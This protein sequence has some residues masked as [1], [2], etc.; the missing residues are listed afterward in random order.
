MKFWF[1][2]LLLACSACI[3]AEVPLIDFARHE[4][5]HDVKISPNGEYLAA[6]AVVNG[7]MVLTLLHLGDLKGVNIVPRE[8]DEL[9]QFWW[10]APTRVMYTVGRKI[11]G[12]EVPLA[13][14]ELFTVAADGSEQKMIFGYGGGTNFQGAT[15][16]QHA[17]SEAAFGEF[18]APLHDDPNS[19]L[20]ASYAVNGA[21]LGNVRTASSIGVFPEAFRIDLRTGSKARV[22]TSPLRNAQFI[23]D[24]KGVVRIAYGIDVDR[25]EKVYYRAGNGAD[26]E[27]IFDQSH[28]GLLVEP[29]AFGSDA[30]TLYLTCGGV[31]G[32]G[33]IC[34]WDSQTRKIQTVWSGIE[35]GPTELMLKADESDAFAIESMPGRPAVSL[36]DKAAPDAK[37]IADLMQQFSGQRV[38]LGAQTIDGTKRIVSVSG[39]VNPGEFYLLDLKT[40]K[41][42]FLLARRPWLKSEQL[43]PMEP[44]KIAARDGVNLHGYLTRPSGKPDAKDAPLVVYVHGGP[45]GVRDFWQ[46][47]PEVQ[48]LASRGYAVLQ[49]NYRGS[50]GY[51]EKFQQSGFREWGGKMQDDI[52]DATHW[53]IEQGI[54]NPKRICI[55]G[56]SYG[57]YAALEGAVREPDLYKCTIGNAGIYDLRLMYSRGDIP[58]SIFGEN[59]LKVVLGE[60]QSQLYDRSPIAHLDKL[61]AHVMLI[62]GGADVR[63]P[64]V[65]AENLHNALNQRKIDHEWIYERTEGHGFYDEKHIVGMYEKILAFLD[66]EI[67]PASAVRK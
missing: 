31:N 61:K 67:G 34:R 58:Q 44:F 40:K 29:R 59:Y 4:R 62:V 38:H 52:T 30:K 66:R 46:Y 55:Y 26:W 14:G 47:D 11:G 54:A 50:G 37:L 12:L 16:I 1:C 5:Y 56:G 48:M 43:A 64:P 28:D 10:V 32:V 25:M 18:I 60:D 65:Q 45:H 20:I 2:G 23:A 51:G 53:A 42:S 8:T 36:L 39:D 22:A 3:A 49:V 63:V 41:L 27:V 15:H 33:G 6:S 17:T 24:Q 7:K 13:T 19:A 21:T 57:G 35:S 9:A